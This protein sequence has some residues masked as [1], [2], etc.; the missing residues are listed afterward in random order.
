VG[1]EALGTNADKN[2]SGS[3]NTP[4]QSKKTPKKTQK[5]AAQAAVTGKETAM[6]EVTA[7]PRSTRSSRTK[8]SE[9]SETSAVKHHHKAPSSVTPEFT[10]AS[11]E[12][13]IP[14]LPTS[15]ARVVTHDAI[16][17]LAYSYWVKRDYRHG[18]AE[19]DWFRAERELLDAR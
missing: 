7:K 5:T 9:L 19:E 14:A 11:T 4:M 18:S 15:P 16:A 6:T 1:P 13:A 8:K 10:A 2:V 17:E 12:S 3:Y